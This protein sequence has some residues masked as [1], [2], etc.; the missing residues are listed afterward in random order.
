MDSEMPDKKNKTLL[1]LDPSLNTLTPRHSEIYRRYQV[2]RVVISF[3]TAAC[4]VAGSLL[5]LSPSTTG[6]AA[7]LFLVGSLM[8]AV[9]PTI[10]M[11]RAFHLRRLPRFM[12][13]DGS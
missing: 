1:A 2:V 4:F 11:I 3:G 6:A 10:D 8:F 9:K 12:V 5:F 13:T 7:R